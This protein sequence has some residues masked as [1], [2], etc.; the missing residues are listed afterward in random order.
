MLAWLILISEG[1]DLLAWL[2][3]ILEGYSALA[4]SVLNAQW[5]ARASELVVDT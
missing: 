3:M 5:G 2:I 4:W 1:Y